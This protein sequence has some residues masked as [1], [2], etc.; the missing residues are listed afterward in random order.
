MNAAIQRYFGELGAV[1]GEGTH[2]SVG[3]GVQAVEPDPGGW[4]NKCGECKQEVSKC[5]DLD[6]LVHL[7]P[8]AHRV[9]P[10]H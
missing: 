8:L 5:V 10:V 4:V 9:M 7:E 2:A 3:D 6:Q 1:V